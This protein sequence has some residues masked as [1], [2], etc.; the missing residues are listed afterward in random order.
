MVLVC[1]VVW[2]EVVGTKHGAKGKVEV[3][4]R[5]LSSLEGASP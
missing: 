2:E 3:E 4:I 5:G 1:V